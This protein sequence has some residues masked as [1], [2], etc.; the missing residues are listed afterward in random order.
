MIE[1][2]KV[3]KE[4]IALDLGNKQTKIKTRKEV[5]VY[6][7]K[8][9]DTISTGSIDN[10]LSNFSSDFKEQTENKDKLHRYQI[11]NHADS[12]FWGENLTQLHLTNEVQESIMYEG[13]Y[14]TDLYKNLV[15]FALARA[16]KPLVKNENEKL[17]IDVATG[18][19]T[20]EYTIGNKENEKELIKVIKGDH[21]VQIDGVNYNF[22]V[23]NLIILPQPAGT[24][25]DMLL[26][27]DGTIKTPDLLNE[28]VRVIDIGGGTLILNEFD[29]F[30]LNS[31][32]ESTTFDGAQ[33]LFNVIKSNSDEQLFINKIEDAFRDAEKNNGEI[34]Y[35]RNNSNIK[36]ITDIS[37]RAIKYWTNQVINK[38]NTVFAGVEEFDRTIFTGGSINL[39]DRQ[40]ILKQIKNAQFVKNGTTANVDGFYKL[41]SI[42]NEQNKK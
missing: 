7:S 14:T 11:L 37:K 31:N 36:N 33:K 4:L 29:N 13:R 17:I 35:H 30:E 15:N 23:D 12:Y 16:I 38:I 39:V 26:N 24:L 32:V 18:M 22:K 3:R 34:L 6:P 27:L 19:P 40:L 1:S 20:A 9:I 2:N 28:K 10:N 42:R 21:S 5:I 25:Y 8:L 41:L